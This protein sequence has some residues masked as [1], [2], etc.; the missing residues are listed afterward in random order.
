M[1]SRES[2]AAV[3]RLARASRGLSRDQMHEKARIYP[4]QLHGLENGK[5]GVTLEML[6]SIAE[7]LDYDPLA[8]LIVASSYDAQTTVTERLAVIKKELANLDALRIVSDMPK[9]FAEGKLIAERAGRSL[10]E[11]VIRA[12]L[13]CRNQ[14]LNQPETAEKLGIHQ[15]TV[16]RIWRRNTF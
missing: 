10:S 15:S 3:L 1:V 14:G 5:G 12:A 4:S 2:L 11:D 16:S 13:A 6:G 8:L 7:A 9:H